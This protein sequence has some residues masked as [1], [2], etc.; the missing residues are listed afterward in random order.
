M[1]A[2]ARFRQ[3]D[4]K[5]AVAGVVAAGVRVGSVAIEPDGRIVV[6]PVGEQSRARKDDG[7][8]DGG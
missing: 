6:I 8:G 7:W 2:P 4:V 5:R 3:E 1:T